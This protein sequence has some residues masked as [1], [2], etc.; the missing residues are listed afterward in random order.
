MS[1]HPIPE[2]MQLWHKG[3]LTAEQA[4]GYMMQHWV[5]WVQWRAEVEKR[6]RQLEQAASK[7][8]G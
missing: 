7:P 1:T 4:V 8:Q 2:L 6:L 3:E 5:E